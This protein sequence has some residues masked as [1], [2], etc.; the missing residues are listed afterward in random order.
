MG[1]GCCVPDRVLH[2]CGLLTHP[3]CP[4]QTEH[5]L[6]VQRAMSKAERERVKREAYEA[7]RR[8][9]YQSTR[10]RN[11][12]VKPLASDVDN[13]ALHH[14]FSEFGEIESAHVMVKDGVSQGFGAGAIR[15]RAPSSL[16]PSS[17][18]PLHATRVRLLPRPC[19]GHPRHRGHARPHGER[20]Q[21][22]GHALRHEGGA[23]APA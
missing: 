16:C 5:H 3:W 11:L 13:A 10:G 1:C 14:M 7:R 22:G 15:G 19:R 12:Y 20:L 4:E 23:T 21:D 6:Y 9:T 2:P 8:Q 18:P 17:H